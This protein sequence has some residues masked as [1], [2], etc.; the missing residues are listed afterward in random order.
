MNKVENTNKS[1]TPYN[2]DE[3]KLTKYDKSKFRTW[4]LFHDQFDTLRENIFNSFWSDPF[5]LNNRNYRV[6]D[7][8]D[9]AKSYTIEVE[10]PRFKRE[11]IKLEIVNGAIQ[12]MAQN[13]RNTYTKLWEL[14]NMDLDK[15]SSR[16]ENGVLTIS[17]EKTPESQPKLIEIK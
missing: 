5:L 4:D 13:D 11:E 9:D 2:K 3:G 16:L 15:V 17:V 7:V 1:V 12:L 8:K 10:L 6:Y 14:P